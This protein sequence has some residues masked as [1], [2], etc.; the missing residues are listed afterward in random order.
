MKRTFYVY[1]G[2]YLLYT[3]LIIL[4]PPMPLEVARICMVFGWLSFAFLGF[5]PM[6]IIFIYQERQGKI[7]MKYLEGCLVSFCLRIAI[8]LFAMYGLSDKWQILAVCGFGMFLYY[9]FGMDR[10]IKKIDNF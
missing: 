1:W 2:W 4:D 5:M 3:A 6:Y 7:D 10:A 8:T 9:I